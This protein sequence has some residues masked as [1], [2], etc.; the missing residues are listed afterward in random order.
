M[1]NDGRPCRYLVI[2]SNAGDPAWAETRDFRA[3][4]VRQGNCV[5]FRRM[6]STI[7]STRR[8]WAVILA[9]GDGTRLAELSH[10]AS[11]DARPK[12][13]C[14][15]FGGKSLLTHTRERIGPLFDRDR[16]LFALARAH[17]R[18]YREELE[19]TDPSARLVQPAN[20]G[21]AVAMAL[22]LKRIVERD[23]DALVAFFPSDHHYA[24]PHAFRE[25]VAAALRVIGQYPDSVLIFGAES[26]YPE[27]EYGWIEPGRKLVDSDRHPLRRVRRFWEKPT[28]AQAELLHG[29]G[30]L[31]NTFVI[32]GLAGTFLAM[33]DANLPHL[34]SAP[35]SI[36]R[37]HELEPFYEKTASVDFSKAVL[38]QQPER[39]IV[40]PDAVSGWT[41][42]GSPARLATVLSDGVLSQS[43]LSRGA[44]MTKEGAMSI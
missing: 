24:N 13:F 39:L 38:M 40:A 2:T 19:D 10:R 8:C 36:S 37:A 44:G 18:Y 29:N 17:D 30:C 22:S 32:L 16:T 43:F 28:R 27:V 26:R 31:W 12:Q 41:D 3:I 25:N 15:F 42:L 11:G 21:T 34:T 9:G 35:V 4:C 5:C 14:R 20:R 7:H 33:I 6:T 1:S 23:E